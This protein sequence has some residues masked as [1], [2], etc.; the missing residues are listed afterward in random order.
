MKFSSMRYL[1]GQGV[2]SVWTN[3]VMSLASFCVLMVS[4][5]LVGFSILFTANITKLITGIEAQNEVIIYL[6]DDLADTNVETIGQGLKGI[7]NVSSV[8]FYSKEEAFEHMKSTMENAEQI[9]ASIEESPL[10]DCYR[11][12]VKDISIM[13]TTLMEINRRWGSAGTAEIDSIASPTDFTSLLT[14]L[15]SMIA[16]ISGVIVI[17]L[18]VVCMVII[19]NSTRA[20][21][22]ARRKEI[23]IMKY[24]GATNSF[25][26]IPFFV[27]GM[28]VGAL[29]GGVAGFITWFAYDKLVELLSQDMTLWRAL[30]LTEFIPF[31]S[32]IWQVFASYVISG[33][34][35]CAVGTA[36]ST[37]KHL[38]V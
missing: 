21:V 17:A 7:D 28:L 35:L 9:F 20:S 13:S 10:P 18:V 19:S 30:N 22:F 34:L 2:K 12:R 29:A 33:A 25:I 8:V 1:V 4:L 15:R 6:K 32:I 11:I 23:N 16:L 36:G 27:E 24:V 14:S 31:Q 26:R 38:K 5:L 3:R 37:R